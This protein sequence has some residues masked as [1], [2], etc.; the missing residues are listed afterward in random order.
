MQLCRLVQFFLGTECVPH[1]IVVPTM[2]QA[3]IP[4]VFPSQC[5]PQWL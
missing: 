4:I 5:S 3:Q 1:D 2:I